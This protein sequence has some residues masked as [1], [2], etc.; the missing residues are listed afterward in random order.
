VNKEIFKGKKGE[1]CPACKSGKIIES[2]SIEV[3]N[4]FPLGK[5]YAE[6]MGVNYS[7][8]EG[9]QKPV[10]FASYG[11]GPTRT[12]GAWVE[13]SHDKQGIIWN[14]A[15]A[16]FDAHLIELRTK[17]SELRTK[18]IYDKLTKE[19]IDVLWDDRDISAGTKF[20]DADLIGIPV[21]L[22]VSDKTKNK[23]EWRE[24]I[25]GKDELMSL[26]KAV[27][28]LKEGG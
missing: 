20:T 1:R 6:K 12:M 16:P 22:V 11:V 28:R 10:W 13:V 26:D 3:G 15:I 27:Q 8:M 17:N 7:D 9:K 21:R 5:W 2:K 24:R 23:V 4:I 25:E 14:K 18:E 19:G